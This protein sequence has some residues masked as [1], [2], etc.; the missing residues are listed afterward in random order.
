M[1]LYLSLIL[2]W[3]RLVCKKLSWS[4]TLV[5]KWFNIKVKA[6]DFHSDYAVEDG[7]LILHHSAASTPFSLLIKDRCV[8]I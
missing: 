4:K 2:F 5:R 6:K 7:T 3:L 8:W 1:F